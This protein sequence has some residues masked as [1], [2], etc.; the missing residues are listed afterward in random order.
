MV[1]SK[2]FSLPEQ[3]IQ[4]LTEKVKIRINDVEL[5]EKGKINEGFI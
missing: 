1:A 2:D 4:A 5:T 3:I